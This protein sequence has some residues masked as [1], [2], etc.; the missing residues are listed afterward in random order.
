VELYWIPLGAGGHCVHHCGVA[1]EAI[2]AARRRRRRYA[3][4]HAALV[5]KS[6]GDRSTIELAPSAAAWPGDCGSFATRSAA[7]AVDRSRISVR[8]SADPAR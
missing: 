4:Y 2:E 3:L 1:F 6:D 8:R 5:V 7:G